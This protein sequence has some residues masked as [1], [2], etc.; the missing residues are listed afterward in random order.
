LSSRNPE[1]FRCHRNIFITHLNRPE[2]LR[3]TK[4]SSNKKHNYQHQKYQCICAITPKINLLRIYTVMYN[5]L[6]GLYFSLETTKIKVRRLF[7]SSGLRPAVLNLCSSELAI[8]EKLRFSRTRSRQRVHNIPRT[9][10]TCF[11]WVSL[12]C[13]IRAEYGFFVKDI[14]IPVTP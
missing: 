13:S 4:K 10:F 6:T 9:N 11:F 3:K 2:I 7:R 1:I 14:F 5:L 12:D 8:S